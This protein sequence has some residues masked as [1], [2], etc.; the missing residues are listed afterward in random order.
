MR[1]RNILLLT[2]LGTVAAALLLSRTEKGKQLTKDLASNAGHLRDKLMNLAQK[3][4]D[5][6]LAL[7]ENGLHEARKYAKNSREAV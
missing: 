6:A 7:S 5:D 4:K 1:T 3:A 2:A